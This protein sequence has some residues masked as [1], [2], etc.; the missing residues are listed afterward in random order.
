MGEQTGIGL[1]NR[2]EKERLPS[3]HPRMFW[4][5]FL[6]IVLLWVW[7]DALRQVSLHTIPYSEFKSR[8]A[9][10]EVSECIVQ[11]RQLLRDQLPPSR[12]NHSLP[13]LRAQQIG[14]RSFRI[15][16]NSRRTHTCSLSIPHYCIQ[17]D[18]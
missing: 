12:V 2:S 16:T 17:S 10:G 4:Y 13:P 6:M 9:R 18:W 8:L 3:I 7:Q 14:A 5:L 1:K 11:A 15:R